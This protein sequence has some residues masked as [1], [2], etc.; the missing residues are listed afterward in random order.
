MVNLVNTTHIEQ[1]LVETRERYTTL[2]K[3][4]IENGEYNRAVDLLK[5]LRDPLHKEYD[6]IVFGRPSGSAHIAAFELLLTDLENMVNEPTDCNR[7]H[8]ADDM[9]LYER[10]A[11]RAR[12]L[13]SE[14]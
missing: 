10:L 11:S 2:V 4:A 6:S 13:R 3:P 14:H 8:L 7:A 1:L 9:V 5:K 12:Q